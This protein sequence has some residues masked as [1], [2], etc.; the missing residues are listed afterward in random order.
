MKISL[1]EV[2]FRESRPFD[3]WGVYLLGGMTLILAVII[4]HAIITGTHYG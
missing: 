4:L 1:L 3:K 2:E